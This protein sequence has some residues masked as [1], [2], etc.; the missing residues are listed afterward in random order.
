MIYKGFASHLNQIITKIRL[1][2]TTRITTIHSDVTHHV[3]VLEM[4]GWNSIGCLGGV[5][6]QRLMLQCYVTRYF[7]WQ[8]NAYN[9]SVLHWHT[10][11]VDSV[12]DRGLQPKQ[13]QKTIIYSSYN[14]HYISGLT[15][16][17]LGL[18]QIKMW[19]SVHCKYIFQ[20][21]L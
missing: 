11:Q 2:R 17:L 16:S 6:I 10:Q 8:F 5:G 20:S 15:E 14:T 1:I 4:G 19:L 9:C 7:S 21:I 18:L 12:T 13:Y 3:T